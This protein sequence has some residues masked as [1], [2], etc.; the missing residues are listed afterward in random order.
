MKRT[1][2]KRPPRRK[3]KTLDKGAHLTHLRVPLFMK[4]SATAT[5]TYERV[6]IEFWN[7]GFGA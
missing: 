2:M 1:Q 7:T 5:V 3:D 6:Q 4:I